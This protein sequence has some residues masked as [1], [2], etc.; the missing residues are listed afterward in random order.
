MAYGALPGHF[1][2]FML[3]RLA[4]PWGELYPTLIRANHYS[5]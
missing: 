4:A 1:I 5:R 3:P 2:G